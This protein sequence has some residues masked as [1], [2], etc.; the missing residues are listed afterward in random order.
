MFSYRYPQFESKRLLRAEML[1]E[2]R[3]YPIRFMKAMWDGYAQGI[4][5]GCAIS[6]SKDVLTV[7]GG[8]IYR[9]KQFYFMESFRA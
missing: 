7:S 3:D 5:A 4:A 6:W 8:A 2:L 1:N 9:N